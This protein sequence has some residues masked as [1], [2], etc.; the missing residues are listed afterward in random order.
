MRWRFWLVT[1]PATI[2]AAWF[3]I[4]GAIIAVLVSIVLVMGLLSLVL[5]Q[6]GIRWGW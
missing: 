1:L 3:Q 5:G 4:Y 2:V 6:F